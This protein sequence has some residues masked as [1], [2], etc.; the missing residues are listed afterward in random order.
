MGAKRAV[1]G[2]NLPFDALLA[3]YQAKRSEQQADRK[4]LPPMSVVRGERDIAMSK[5]DFEVLVDRVKACSKDGSR[6]SIMEGAWHNHSI[7][8]PEVF[9]K[10]IHEWHT[11]VLGHDIT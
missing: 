3:D 10:V 11:D 7:D 5:R 6:S 9:A 8:V 1:S 2:R 4:V